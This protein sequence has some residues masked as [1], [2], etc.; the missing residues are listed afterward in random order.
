MTETKMKKL[1]HTQNR[2]CNRVVAETDGE[3]IYFDGKPFPRNPRKI[4]F[5][6]PFCRQLVTWAKDGE[7]RR[8]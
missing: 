3:N 2:E 1:H 8:K 6:C 4:V 7:K 5:D